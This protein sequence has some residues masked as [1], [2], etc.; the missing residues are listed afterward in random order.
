MSKGKKRKKGSIV[1]FVV[2]M[3]LLV[4]GALGIY[5]RFMAR[6]QSSQEERTPATET[7]K[8]IA[9]DLEAGYPET[10]KEVMKLFGR[11]NQCIYNKSLSDEELSSLVN[12]LWILYSEDLKKEN[13]LEKVE[14]NIRSE[15]KDFNKK[16]KKIVNY[17]IDEERNYQYKTIE[18]REMVYLKYSYFVRDGSDYST[19]NQKAILVKEDDKWKL[20]GFDSA[21]RKSEVA[22]K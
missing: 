1:A 11:L 21:G 7:E 5:Y 20:Y 19:W 10:P 16:K 2:V 12:Q 15:V 14:K 13:S 22:A 4:A 18:G 9:K 8:L 17:T 6:Q 3:C